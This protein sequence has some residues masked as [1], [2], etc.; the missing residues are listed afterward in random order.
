LQIEL[1]ERAMKG[2]H[3]AFATLVRSEI[4][5]LHGL[6]GLV[7]RDGGRAED[8][9]QEALLNAWRDLPRLRDPER[10]R[11]WLRRLLINASHDEGRR[12]GRRRGEVTFETTHEPRAPD[13]FEAML[14]REELGRAFARLT[15]EQRTVLSLRYYLDLS[16][17]DGAAAMGMRESTYRSKIHRAL[18]AM[19]AALADVA[20]GTSQTEGHST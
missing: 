11:A 9:V 15:T 2:D 13:P 14:Q 16:S 17:T 6:A 19:D 10:F 7:L 4:G 1:V 8:A 5:S 3:D 18:R 12:L 20:R